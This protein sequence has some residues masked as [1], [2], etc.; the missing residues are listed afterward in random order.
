MPLQQNKY[1]QDDF[2]TRFISLNDDLCCGDKIRFDLAM[3]EIRQDDTLSTAFANSLQNRMLLWNQL[4]DFHLIEEEKHNFYPD[5][6]GI[7]LKY[8]YIFI[9]ILQKLDNVTDLD[10]QDVRLL[11]YE[12]EFLDILYE[13][14]NLQSVNF[15][16]T[17]L[18]AFPLALTRL[19]GL[20]HLDLSENSII[21][22]PDDIGNMRAILSLNLSSNH[23]REIPF[24]IGDL[25]ELRYLML[26]QNEIKILPDELSNLTQIVHLELWKNKLISLPENIG[27]LQKIKRLRLNQNNLETLPESIGNIKG[28][29]ELSVGDNPQFHTLPGRLTEL[30]QLKKLKTG[31][32]IGLISEEDKTLTKMQ[33][34]R[35]IDDFNRSSYARDIQKQLHKKGLPKQAK[36]S[37]SPPGS[38]P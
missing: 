27:N 4:I 20:Q 19:P 32:S 25:T 5:I 8:N 15:S 7:M 16:H 17:G 12:D 2:Q 35:F 33:L 38:T 36:Q 21:E 23:I 9:P 6:L 3:L 24:S 26:F 22:I 29:I 14:R 13:L 37:P 31:F 11:G 18:Q 34:Q 28:L 30:T 10:L 1:Q